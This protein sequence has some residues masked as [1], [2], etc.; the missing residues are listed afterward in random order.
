MSR[1]ETP[2]ASFFGSL[3]FVLPAT[4]T[5]VVSVVLFFVAG[6]LIAGEKT[7][8]EQA[9]QSN[10]G[11]MLSL[12]A[13][14][15]EQPVSDRD[16]KSIRYFLTSL[17]EDRDIVLASV[18]VGDP[19]HPELECMEVLHE[20]ATV[21]YQHDLAESRYIEGSR[22]VSLADQSMANIRLVASNRHVWQKLGQQVIGIIM[23]TMLVVIS[24]SIATFVL[25]HRLIFRPVEALSRSAAEIAQGNLKNRVPFSRLNEIGSLAMQM[26][27]MR[28]SL[29]KLIGALDRSKSELEHRVEERTQDLL[30]AKEAA[31]IANRAKS[32][33]LANMSHE[34]R[35]PMNG[36][37]GMT[38]VLA[39][40]ELSGDQRHYAET[41]QHSALSLLTIINDILDFSKIEAGHLQLEKRTI[42]LKK[43]MESVREMFI[44]DVVAK[45]L[46]LTFQYPDELPA[47]VEGDDVRIRQ[48]LTNLVGNAIKFTHEGGV[49]IDVKRV[50]QSAD[51]VKIKVSVHDTGVGIA[52]EK[53]EAVFNKFTQADLSTTRKF[54][55]TG[56]GLSI[57]RQL[58][59]MMGGRIGLTS[60]PDRGTTFYF[61][62]T[63]P[64]VKEPQD[65]SGSEGADG[66]EP[67]SFNAKALVAEDN[68]VN[69]MVARKFLSSLGLTV[70]VVGNGL[71]AVELLAKDPTF[72]VVFLDCQMPVMDGYTA[73]AEIRKLSGSAAGLPIVAMTAHAMTGDRE[74]CIAAGMNEYITKPVKKEML[75][76]VLHK[77]LA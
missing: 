51:S 5:V 44:P 4:L 27:K 33:F 40:T 24:L 75:A 55:G 72:E 39:E 67:D 52:K 49:F 37:I 60:E 18:T 9:I 62:L 2:A 16:E 15:L 22:M 17:L 11:R 61:V 70:E 36:V 77:V 69:Q 26:D 53:Q 76:H 46:D 57:S 47:F 35:T 42:N 10:M 25:T 45:G 13:L 30:K 43:V 68:M 64:I 38:D 31:E 3:A 14:A 19:D 65:E 71:Q 73:A 66:A 58:V 12:S 34:L 63:L 21:A 7:A 74:K 23:I 20:F 28:Q 6:V 8:A 41:I 56:L 50:D 32:E 29:Q 59:E 48:V 1:P 54:G